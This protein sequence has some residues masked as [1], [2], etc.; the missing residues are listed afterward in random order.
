MDNVIRPENISFDI[1]IINSCIK[2]LKPVSNRK[3]YFDSLVYDRLLKCNILYEEELNRNI[4]L[5]LK[6]IESLSSEEIAKNSELKR[7]FNNLSRA[8]RFLYLSE[9]ILYEEL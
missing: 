4:D 7:A 2:E 8:S 6:R 1:N 9:V 5:F 3:D